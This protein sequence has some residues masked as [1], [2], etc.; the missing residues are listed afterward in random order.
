METILVLEDIDVVKKLFRTVL[1]QNGFEV[2]E[3]ETIDEALEIQRI[4]AR[5][6]DLVIAN[7]ELPNRA[8]GTQAAIELREQ[9]PHLKILFCSGTPEEGLRPRDLQN[10]A[11]LTT[12]SYSFMA[13]PFLPTI[14][15]QKIRDLL[16]VRV[17]TA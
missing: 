6:V 14:L 5:P 13:K 11:K 7:L 8:S 4:H 10:M 1:E 12:G 15:L 16:A 2:L 9:L 3:A 17:K